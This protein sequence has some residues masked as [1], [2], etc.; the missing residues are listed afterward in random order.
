MSATT[1]IPEQST[2]ALGILETTTDPA[3]KDFLAQT[4][5]VGGVELSPDYFTD[6]HNWSNK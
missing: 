5:P 3:M 4:W 6:W 2:G 1:A